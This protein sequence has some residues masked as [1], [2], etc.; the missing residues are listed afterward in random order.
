M[1]RSCAGQQASRGFPARTRVA[2][3]IGAPL[4]RIRWVLEASFSGLKRS[5]S[6]TDYSLSFSAE[7]KNERI[8]PS[9]PALAY[10]A[11]LN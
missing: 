6:E 5:K 11:L 2:D 7:V 8:Y 3:R 1:T 4:R 10:M 9:T